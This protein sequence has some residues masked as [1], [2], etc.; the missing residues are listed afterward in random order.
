M[1]IFRTLRDIFDGGRRSV[2]ELQGGIVNA[3][4][5]IRVMLDP[6]ARPHKVSG[7]PD[8]YNQHARM[9]CGQVDLSIETV[10]PQYSDKD[11]LQFIVDLFTEMLTRGF[12]GIHLEDTVKYNIDGIQYALTIA[13]GEIYIPSPEAKY[14]AALERINRHLQGE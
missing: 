9:L 4:A 6:Q 2:A 5:E 7:I 10:A 11:R 12:G 13:T 3:I 14:R 1:S 8:V